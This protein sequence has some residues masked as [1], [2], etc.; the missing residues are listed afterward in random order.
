MASRVRRRR[1][2]DGGIV[3]RAEGDHGDLRGLT[4]DAARGLH[5]VELR[6]VP[7]HD[8]DIR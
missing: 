7:V 5:A 2:T 4:P 3:G 8:H 1:V 6:H